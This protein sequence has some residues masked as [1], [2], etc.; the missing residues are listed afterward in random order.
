MVLQVPPIGHALEH[1]GPYVQRSRPLVHQSVQ[2]PPARSHE[3][4]Q[5]SAHTR[6]QPN[7][8]TRSQA[9]RLAGP[10]EGSSAQS[11]K[12]TRA[13]P[14]AHPHENSSALSPAQACANSSALSLAQSMPA[15]TCLCTHVNVRMGV[16]TRLHTCALPHT[17]P[18]ARPPACTH[19]RLSPMGAS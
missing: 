1:V 10:L 2:P 14:P 7:S 12:R 3:L 16:L 13:R 5:A 17:P 9:R 11:L 19:T 15:C 8:R 6:I 4:T 18:P